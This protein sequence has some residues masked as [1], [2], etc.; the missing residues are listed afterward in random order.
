MSLILITPAPRHHSPYCPIHMPSPHTLSFLLQSPT[1]ASLWSPN[2][3][4]F[5]L[6]P[7]ERTTLAIR[8]EG[9]R[10]ADGNS[11]SQSHP[12]VCPWIT[13]GA[14]QAAAWR[15]E[16][17]AGALGRHQISKSSCKNSFSLLQW[18]W[19]EENLPSDRDFKDSSTMT[20]AEGSFPVKTNFITKM[21]WLLKEGNSSSF[22][23][24]FNS[25]WPPES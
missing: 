20:I 1:P 13:R 9:S 14:I 4:H 10:D 5:F 3:Y 24:A 17:N 25:T 6:F 12:T 15:E 18:T 23:P 21:T 16:K 7:R 22:C 2:I 19:L 11:R 8:Q